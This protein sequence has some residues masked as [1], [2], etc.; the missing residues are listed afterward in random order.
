MGVLNV[1]DLTSTLSAWKTKYGL[2]DEAVSS[3]QSLVSTV[4][5]DYKQTHQVLQ[6]TTG[7]VK[8][9]AAGGRNYNG[10]ISIA[11]V[12]GT[13]SRSVTKHAFSISCV[14]SKCAVKK[15]F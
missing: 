5:S 13:N 15:T 1:G 9:V 12:F 8:V 10:Q 4:S 3:L 2:P 14:C 6:P 11:F 7:Q